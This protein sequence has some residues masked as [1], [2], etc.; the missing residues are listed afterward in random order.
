[1]CKQVVIRFRQD[2]LAEVF[3]EGK[4][5]HIAHIVRMGER[6]WAIVIDDGDY[7]CVLHAVEEIDLEDV[8]GAAVELRD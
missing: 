5:L 3:A 2:E 7:Q 6:E 4:W 8:E 1:M